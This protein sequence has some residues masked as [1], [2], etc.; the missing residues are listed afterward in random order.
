VSRVSLVLAIV[1]LL[2]AFGI[3]S[4]IVTQGFRQLAEAE[5]ERDQLRAEKQ[6]LEQRIEELNA[7]LEALRT[8]PAAVESLARRDLGWVR[9]GDTVIVLATPTPAA[10]ALTLTGPTP[11]PILSLR[12]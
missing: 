2:V 4:S 6:R 9:P 10:V 1:A 3:L 5:Q 8:D 7:T 11:T 12:Q